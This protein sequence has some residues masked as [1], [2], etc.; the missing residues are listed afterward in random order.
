MLYLCSVIVWLFTVVYM[1]SF[2]E[3]IKEIIIIIR[4]CELYDVMVRVTYKT[5]H[6]DRENYDK[7]EK[8][9]CHKM[10]SEIKNN[11]QTNVIKIIF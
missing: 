7:N 9:I 6:T 1:L 10:P 2:L 8:W 3:E 5:N 11:S 4:V